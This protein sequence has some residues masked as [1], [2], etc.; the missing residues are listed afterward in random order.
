MATV[1][2][3]RIKRNSKINHRANTNHVETKKSGWYLFVNHKKS[4][5]SLPKATSNGLK[6]IPP[7]E[8]WEGDDYYFGLVRSRLA[9]FVKEIPIEELN[10]Q[11]KIISEN[12]VTTIEKDKKNTCEILSN[13]DKFLEHT[14]FPNQENEI[15]SENEQKKE[16]KTMSEKLILDQAPCVTTEGNVEQYV[17]NPENITNLED[18]GIVM[19]DNVKTTKNKKTKVNEQKQKD[20][21]LNDSPISGIQILN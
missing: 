12:I 14:S 21:L 11:N 2:K 4:E 3:P 19:L 13:S 15:I 18:L 5:L 6:S 16:N 8:T 10:S 9:Q 1:Q 20:V 7:N 17:V